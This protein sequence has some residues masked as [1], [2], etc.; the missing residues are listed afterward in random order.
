MALQTSFGFTNN[1]TRTEAKGGNRPPIINYDMGITNNYALITDEPDTVQLSNTT[2]PVDQPEVITYQYSQ[3]KKIPT[4]VTISNPSPNE[5]V[6][7]MYGVR[8]DEVVRETSSVDETYIRDYPIVVNVS[9]KHPLVSA[10]TNTQVE[11]A[12]ARAVSALFSDDGK[13]RIKQLMRDSLKPTVN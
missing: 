13:S 8:A 7:V 12:V 9:V 5:N 10:I 11:V 4:V 3:L 2:S 6:N 1:T